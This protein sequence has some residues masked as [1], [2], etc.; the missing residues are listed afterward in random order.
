MSTAFPGTGP[1]L[2]NKMSD[3]ENVR[4]LM[5]EFLSNNKD[6]AI[7]LLKVHGVDMPMFTT[8]GA[9]RVA[10]IKA[11]KDSGSFRADAAR[12]M[13]ASVGS[14]QQANF[15]KQPAGY[16]NTVDTEPWLGGEPP[17]STTTPTT[18]TTTTQKSG[19]FWSSLGSIFTPELIT[20]G[21]NT[22]LDTL[23]AKAQADANKVGEE[24]AL[25]Y[26]AEKTRQLQTQL[27]IEQAKAGKKPGM[28]AWAWITISVVVVGGTVLGVV[29]SRRRS[30]ARKAAA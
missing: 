21:I 8:G 18:T 15:I 29:L 19:G 13:A 5:A 26:E 14:N 24:N 30:R 23:S 7:R 17:A 25:R 9:L 12:L 27:E 11:I 10:F 3:P 16:F 1:S 4:L 2:E 28:P 6:A 20:K 22:G